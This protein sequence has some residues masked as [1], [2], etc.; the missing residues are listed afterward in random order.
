MQNNEEVTENMIIRRKIN[1]EYVLSICIQLQKSI[2]C[3]KI[4]NKDIADATK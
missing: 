4:D 3:W 1:L 2:Y